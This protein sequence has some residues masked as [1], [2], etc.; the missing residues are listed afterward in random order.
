MLIARVVELGLH[1]VLLYSFVDKMI[2]F[3]PAHDVEKLKLLRL[4]EADSHRVLNLPVD[5]DLAE[6]VGQR[7]DHFVDLEDGEEL[8]RFL[9][10]VDHSR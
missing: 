3:Q 8:T 6:H 9:F 10:E 2:R 5:E 7:P 1:V 4:G